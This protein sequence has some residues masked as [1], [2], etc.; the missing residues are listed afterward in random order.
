MLMFVPFSEELRVDHHLFV[1]GGG[2]MEKRIPICIISISID[3][4]R[5]QF[6]FV[7]LS[8]LNDILPSLIEFK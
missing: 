8:L 3:P 7:S 1:M 6:R 2:V 5:F 4:F